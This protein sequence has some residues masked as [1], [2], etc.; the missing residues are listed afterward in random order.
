MS[1]IFYTMEG[2]II[3][4]YATFNDEKSSGSSI[5]VPVMLKSRASLSVAGFS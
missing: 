3:Y 4:D 2:R 5:Q 1:A